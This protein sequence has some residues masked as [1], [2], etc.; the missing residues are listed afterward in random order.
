MVAEPTRTE[1]WTLSLAA[2]FTGVGED[3]SWH[4]R[5]RIES[6]PG[7]V[8]RDGSTGYLVR[9]VDLEESTTAEGPWLRAG[10]DGRSVEMRR[11]AG[12][13]ILDLAQLHHL[14]GAPRHGDVADVV[15]PGLVPSPPS[16]GAGDTR[17][18]RTAWPYVLRKGVGWRQG[19]L[20]TWTNEG[21][22]GVGEGRTARLSYEGKLEG[23]GDDDRYEQS[24]AVTGTAS[25]EVEV[26]VATGKLLRHQLDWTR[27]VALTSP[28]GEANQ[29]QHFVITL[30]ATE[31]TARAAPTPRTDRDD[32]P[33]GNYMEPQDVHDA[34]VPQIGVF[35]SCYA[36][37]GAAGHTEVGEV[38][39][40][41]TIA[42][43]GTV[44]D[45]V[46]RDSRSGFPKLDACLAETT[47]SLHFP[48]HDEEPLRVGYPLVWR[49]S[50]LQVYPMVF[51]KDRPVGEL[52]VM[53]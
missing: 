26:E 16:I 47:A 36:H 44:R 8:F 51:V 23:T 19:L 33:F 52:L 14:S 9:F 27:K 5:G 24:F 12:G 49:E 43:D 13:E 35:E 38:F 29:T 15:F 42:P 18:R 21:V 34:L 53:H 50:A 40:D 22:E 48:G 1:A 39:L 46:V 41:F 4:L 28:S 17:Y 37:S 7:R 10:L 32:R 31:P 6:D 45:G 2:D 3:R 25:G 20:A 11:F 30:E